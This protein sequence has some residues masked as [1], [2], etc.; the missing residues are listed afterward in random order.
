MRVRIRGI[1][2]EECRSMDELHELV[3]ERFIAKGMSQRQFAAG[4]LTSRVVGVP[5]LDTHEYEWHP[6]VAHA[7]A[8]A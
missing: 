5:S 3:R 6:L 7:A 1:D 4:R 2:I 8:A